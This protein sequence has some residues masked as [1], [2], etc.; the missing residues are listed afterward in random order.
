M[1]EEKPK[2]G[3]RFCIDRFPVR[4]T[5]TAA[6]RAIVCQRQA[7]TSTKVCVCVCDGQFRG[8]TGPMSRKSGAK[9]PN[10][11]PRVHY[12]SIKLHSVQLYILYNDR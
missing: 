7:K 9:T 1:R 5:C 12:V 8:F 2:G 4:R 10:R 3:N 6:I 11:E